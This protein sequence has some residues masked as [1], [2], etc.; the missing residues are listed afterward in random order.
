SDAYDEG[1]E[2]FADDFQDFPGGGNAMRLRVCR[3]LEL[4]RHEVARILTNDFLGLVDR[5]LHRFGARSQDDLGSIGPEEV[6]AFDAVII[7]H[8]ENYLVS[9]RGP[10]HRQADAR[11]AAGRFDNRTAGP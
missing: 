4:L 6:H 10:D 7:R 9:L 2:L 11:V 5:A 3:I 1:I 8:C